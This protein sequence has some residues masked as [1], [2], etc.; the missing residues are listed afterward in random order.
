V[1]PFT[2]F[3][4]LQALNFILITVNYRA[5]AHEQLFWVIASDGV[6]CLLSWTL[7]KRLT[8]A[9]GWPSRS[10]YV[11]GGMVGSAIGMWLTR[12]WS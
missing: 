11:C 7:L 3:M 2:T 8:E 10:G 6:I 9:S 1:R 4:G 12:V 5:V